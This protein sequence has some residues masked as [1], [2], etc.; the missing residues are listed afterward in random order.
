M[1]VDPQEIEKFNRLAADWWDP[2]GISYGALHAINPLRM[3]FITTH[4]PLANQHVLDVGCGGGILT[5]SLAKAGAQLTGLDLAQDSLT[6]ASAHAENNSLSINYLNS[7]VE[8]F[9]D[10]NAG[11]F[12][13]ITCME[14]LEHV[15]D[16]R[17]VI[18]ACATLAK[19]GGH[20]FF[21]TINRNF[22]SYLLAI[23]GAEYVLGLLPK[24]THDY[25]KFIKPS[26]LAA[27]CREYALSWQHTIGLT[28]NPLTRA[29]STTSSTE[30]NYIVHC[31]K[32]EK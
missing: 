6:I 26:E 15:P 9:A 1:N 27:W 3:Q 7:S 13:V 19:P 31:I 14:L 22:K 18:Q 5:E 25:A 16:P 10:K 12:D 2:E 4:A 24:Q 28:Y 29:Y 32:E 8:N 11:A 23:I 20:L 30:V 17:S 21:S